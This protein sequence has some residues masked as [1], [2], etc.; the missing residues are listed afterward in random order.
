MGA[1]V[2]NHFKKS[3]SI[4]KKASIQEDASIIENTYSSTHLDTR[5]PFT[6]MNSDAKYTTNFTYSTLKNKA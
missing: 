5:P 2:S 4:T 3:S 1:V 6:P